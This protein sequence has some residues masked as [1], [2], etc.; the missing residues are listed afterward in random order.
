MFAIKTS[1]VKEDKGSKNNPKTEQSDK[2]AKALKKT[3]EDGLALI[4]PPGK[5]DEE[6]EYKGKI[7][8]L[9]F[10]TTSVNTGWQG[11]FN[12]YAERVADNGSLLNIPCRNHEADTTSKYK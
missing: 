2:S 5:E 1:L 11:G 3:L 4:F 8:G 12:A 9:L 6:K 10:D 7:F